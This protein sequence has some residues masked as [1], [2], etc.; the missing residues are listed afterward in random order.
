MAQA[1]GGGSAAGASSSDASLPN[2]LDPK[3]LVFALL[4]HLQIATERYAQ[5]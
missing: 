5:R 4:G 3:T 1:Q 2:L